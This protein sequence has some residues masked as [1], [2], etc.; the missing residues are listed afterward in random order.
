[1]NDICPEAKTQLEE[2]V[3]RSGSRDR[4]EAHQPEP[5]AGPVAAEGDGVSR[6]TDDIGASPAGVKRVRGEFGLVE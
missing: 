4:G 1:M 5:L 3:D 2:H 6:R